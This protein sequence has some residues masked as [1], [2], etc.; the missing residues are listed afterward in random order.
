MRSFDPNDEY[1]RR[2]LEKLNAEPWMVEC[3][4]LNPEYPHWGPHEDYMIKTGSAGWDSPQTC[5]TWSSFGP[6]ELN[7]L[8]EVVNFYFCIRRPSERCKACDGSGLNPRTKVLHDQFYNVW[9]HKITQEELDML[10]AEGRFVRKPTLERV[11]AENLP[12]AAH[13]GHDGINQML[14]VKARATRLGFYGLCETC[15][16]E[17]Y[18]YTAPKAH[19]GLVLWVLHPRKGASRGVEIERIERAELPAAISFLRE[20]AR[21]NAKR[22]SAFDRHLSLEKPAS[23]GI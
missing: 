7:D 3:I 6:W 18:V 2:D 23:G 21:R 10:V 9:R 4:K 5:D 16:G 12:G 17:G 8:N 11:N 14:L 13:L 1:D 20:A 15:H 19:L 22:F